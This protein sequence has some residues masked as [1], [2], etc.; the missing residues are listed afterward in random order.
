M[1]LAQSGEKR[2][3]MRKVCTCM[4]MHEKSMY[5]GLLWNENTYFTCKKLVNKCNSFT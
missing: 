1:V 4:R 5:F 3:C 2:E